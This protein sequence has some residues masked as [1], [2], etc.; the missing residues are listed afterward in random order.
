MLAAPPAG[1]NGAGTH[2]APVSGISGVLSLLALDEAPVPD[3][4]AVPA[5]LAGTLALVQ[6]LGDAQIA[7]PLWV[8]TRGSVA[9]EAGEPLASPVQAMAWG[10]GQVAALEHPDRWGGLIDLPPVLDR[11]AGTRLC[12]VLAG[13]G[14]DQV[15]IRSAGIMAR[16][17]ARATRPPGPGRAWSPRGAALITGGTGA[18][19][20]HVAR[21]LARV[22]AP[23]IILASRSG[24]AAPAAAALAAAVA[25]AG[26]CAEITACD[27]SR[28]RD[29]AALLT[30]ITASDPPLTTVMHAAGLLDDGVLDGLGS[31]RLATVLAAKA[32]GAAALAELTQDMNLDAFVLFSSAAA[33]FGN[34]GQGNYAAANAFLDAL[35]LYRHGRGQPALSVAWGQWAGG[36]LAQGSE[37]ARQRMRRSGMPAMDPD[38]AVK[39]LGQALDAG[40]HALAVMDVDWSQFA[41]AQGADQVPFLRD[42][43]EISPHARP[44]GADAGETAGRARG[45][46]AQRLAGLPPAEQDRVLAELVLGE[47]AAVLGHASATAIGPDKAFSDLGFDSLT[48]LELRQKV[49]AA[50]G[51]QLPATL[52]F[53]YP[54]P[55]V[56]GE[57]LRAETLAQETGCLSVME[58]LDQ[59]ESV[60]SSITQADEARFKITARLEAIMHE[61]CAESVDNATNDPELDSATDD[62]MFGLIERELGASEFD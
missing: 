22:G 9:A 10:L 31:A 56:L 20:G 54:T 4:P 2:P 13:C 57:Y 30:R 5:G 47:A 62:E 12:T 52:L 28:P 26:A 16:R 32:A 17:L 41:A 40:D 37:A 14:E 42:L 60:L 38:L 8:L 44:P 11:R 58:E 36:G 3:H 59:L 45:E 35:A 23:K 24:P 25:A 18:V 50:T 19:G 49:S 61:F 46:L 21:W 33:T 34:P 1:H 15:A 27:T 53:D 29:L 6:A 7:A 39:A 43:P 55:A 48:A 51:L